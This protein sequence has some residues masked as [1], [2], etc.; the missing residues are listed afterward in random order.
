MF[1]DFTTL[2]LYHGD[3]P[4]SSWHPQESFTPP[5]PNNTNLV[6]ILPV[7]DTKW[8][9]NDLSQMF[10]IELRHDTA[11]QRMRSKPLN[12]AHDPGN[13][14]FPGI[15]RAFSRVIVLQVLKVLDCRRGKRYP[16]LFR[17]GSLQTKAL[18]R[19]EKRDFAAFFQV[20]QP[21]HDSLHKSPLFGLL[22][23]VLE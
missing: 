12:R 1:S 19:L 7:N 14:P 9:V 13:K 3:V 20:H 6:F 2:E 15:R 11:A 5:D 16:C 18:F 8:R 4:G 10:D 17:H 22:L 23:I 21:L